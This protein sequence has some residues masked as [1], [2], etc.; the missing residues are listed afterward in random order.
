MEAVLKFKISWIRSAGDRESVQTKRGHCSYS[1][2]KIPRSFK[3]KPIPPTSPASVAETRKLGALKTNSQ[4]QPQQLGFD[5]AQPQARYSASLMVHLTLGNTLHNWS[6]EIVCMWRFTK[7]N[8]I[9]EG[10][11]R[12]MKLIQ[13]KAYG[14]KNFDNYRLRVRALCC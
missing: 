8:R 6:D 5:L 3:P 10:F 1:L 7:S 11:H 12:K 14:F 13:R 9:T 2:K 4:S